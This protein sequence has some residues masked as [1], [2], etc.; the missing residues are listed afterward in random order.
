MHPSRTVGS[1]S[2]TLL[3]VQDHAI[4]SPQRLRRGPFP[5][6]SLA[7]S[8]VATT[9]LSQLASHPSSVATLH[10]SPRGGLKFLK[11]TIQEELEVLDRSKTSKMCGDHV[12]T[13][14]GHI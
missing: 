8:A 7:P 6:V 1:E 9:A 12:L 2:A 14:V 5:F 10:S 11:E 3:M 4:T 13:C